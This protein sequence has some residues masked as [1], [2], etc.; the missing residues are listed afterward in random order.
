VPRRRCHY[1]ATR[2]SR[3]RSPAITYGQSHGG[4]N[5]HRLSAD[6]LTIILGLALQEGGHKGAVQSP[7]LD[8]TQSASALTAGDL[9]A[10]CWQPASQQGPGRAFV[11][12]GVT[13][14]EPVTSAVMLL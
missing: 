13:G 11:L 1:R 2:S 14:I 9:L 12:V 10:I 3:D 4:R 5:L 8:S 6:Q 7:E